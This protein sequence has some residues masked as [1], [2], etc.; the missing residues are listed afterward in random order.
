MTSTKKIVS[1]VMAVVFSMTMFS[2]FGTVTAVTG[3][4]EVVTLIEGGSQWKY[5]DT[6]TSQYGDAATDFRS[7]GFNDTAWK[8]GKAPLGYPLTDTNPTFGLISDGTLVNNVSK[9]NAILTYYFRKEFTIAD[10]SRVTKLEANVGFDDGFVM[11]I[12]GTEVNRTYMNEGTVSHTTNANYVNEPS[13]P[14]GSTVLDLTSKIALLKNG[15]NK[16]AVSVHNRDADSSDIYFAMN[17]KATLG[18]ALPEVDTTKQPKQVN[19]HLGADAATSVNITY[20]TASTTSTQVVLNKKG[21]TGKTTVAGTEAAGAANKIFHKIPVIGLSAGTEYEYTVGDGTN[22]F[23]GTFKTA[24][25]QGSKDSF[26]FVYLADTQVANATDAKALG[27][28]MEKVSQ[29][30]NLDFVYLAGDIT[31]TSTSEAQ[32]ELLYNNQGAFPDGGQKM[33]RSKA[34]SVIQGNHDND[35]F[36]GHINAPAQEGNVVY[37]YDY[38][39]VKFI[40]LNLEASRYSTDSRA[41]QEA[42]LRAKT[43]EAKAAGQWTIV[44]FH[45]SLYTGASHITDSDVIDARKFW[46]PKFAELDIDMV[47]QGHDH[48]YSRGFINAAGENAK[49]TVGSDGKVNDPANA[50]LYMVGGHAG[51]LKWYSQ[52]NYTVT[53]GDPLTANYSFLDKNSTDDQSDIKQEQWVTEFTVTDEEITIN[54]YCFKYNTTSDTITTPQYLYDTL[55]VKRDVAITADIGG[56]NLGVADINGEVTYTASL[57]DLHNANAFNVEVSYDNSVL[58]LVKSESLLNGTIFTSP[59]NST[60]KAGLLVGVSNGITKTGKTDVVKFTFKVK[61][62]AAYGS[63]EVKLTKADTAFLTDTG[64]KDAAVEIGTEKV[65]TEIYTYIH[66]SDINGDNKITL[67][68]LS[69]ALANYQG[70]DKKFDINLDGTVNTADYI[71]IAGFLIAA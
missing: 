19:V 24:L 25:A 28:T 62:T 33:F 58:E 43:A 71:I 69:L 35:T 7:E 18:A 27:A 14:E 8:T 22:S 30:S 64:S 1:L 5:E 38:G 15:L 23:S 13:T 9:P 67:A 39:M 10:V 56:S 17:L 46:G 31:D 40:M 20:T 66:A 2:S 32:W 65:T 41:K 45:K 55:T 34:I 48:V 59:K 42:F 3:Q 36:N 11:Y 49:P 53:A 16:I 60:G 52:K 54:S 68:D 29:I 63:T 12:N 44:G 51:G 26:K 50:P 21:E 47:L 37:S 57:N 6:N 70:I 61:N 4:D